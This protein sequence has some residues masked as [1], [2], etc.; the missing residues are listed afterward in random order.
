MGDLRSARALRMDDDPTIVA[1]LRHRV[2][3]SP[4]HAG[5]GIS[6]DEAA[7]GAVNSGG[8]LARIIATCKG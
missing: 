8:K 4:F 3:A 1:D 7:A 5:F 2:A 6:V